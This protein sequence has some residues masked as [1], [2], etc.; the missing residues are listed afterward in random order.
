VS[1][2]NV[3][4]IVSGEELQNARYKDL[5]TTYLPEWTYSNVTKTVIRVGMQSR[6]G[7]GVL[8]ILGHYKTESGNGG[9][10]DQPVSISCRLADLSEFDGDKQHA[11]IVN[12]LVGSLLEGYETTLS[13]RSP[14]TAIVDI[15]QHQRPEAYLAYPVAT[16][17]ADVVD[18]CAW[19]S[20]KSGQVYPAHPAFIAR[21]QEATTKLWRYTPQG[22]VE[23]DPEW[24]A[25][26]PHIVVSA[27]LKIPSTVAVGYPL[28]EPD[29]DKIEPKDPRELEQDFKKI[30]RETLRVQLAHRVGL[31][32]LRSMRNDEND[33]VDFEIYEPFS[34]YYHKLHVEYRFYDSPQTAE[35]VC[36]LQFS[37]FGRVM[38]GELGFGYRSK[39]KAIYKADTWL[40]EQPISDQG[41]LEDIPQE[42]N[43]YLNA[44][45]YMT[46][47][48][49]AP[50]VYDSVWRLAIPAAQACMTTYHYQRQDFKLSWMLEAGHSRR[51][52][53]CEKGDQVKKLI[54]NY[55]EMVNDANRDAYT[56]LMNSCHLHEFVHTLAKLVEHDALERQAHRLKQQ[57]VSVIQD[58]LSES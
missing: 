3:R 17:S 44:V 31:S 23:T 47:F 41:V 37:Y 45:A 9:V 6:N 7:S 51:T 55:T 18:I 35:R 49:D 12:K 53:R 54:A 13:E 32:H 42:V 30:L 34:D 27:Q 8:S 25:Q 14:I 36:E 52:I 43:D 16:S 22:L 56:K 21:Q 46:S 11:K 58:L 20:E 40:T 4:E 1:I 10:T 5:L 38:T 50:V 39:F 48:R 28:D 15:G 2:T 19:F 33:A 29:L 24:F 26:H 57:D